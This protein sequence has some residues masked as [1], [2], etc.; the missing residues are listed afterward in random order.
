MSRCSNILVWDETIDINQLPFL[1]CLVTM[2]CQERIFEQ[3]IDD[4]K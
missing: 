1:I 2:P 4:P 3:S